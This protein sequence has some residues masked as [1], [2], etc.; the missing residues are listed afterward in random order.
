MYITLLSYYSNSFRLT[1]DYKQLHPWDLH[2]QLNIGTCN[3]QERFTS[4]TRRNYNFVH[5]TNRPF[6]IK[7]VMKS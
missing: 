6:E 3:G 4:A 2:E 5:T 1:T 7:A